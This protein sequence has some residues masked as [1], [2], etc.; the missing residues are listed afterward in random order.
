MAALRRLKGKQQA[1]PSGILKS[2][3]EGG[4]SYSLV[5]GGSEEKLLIH[6]LRG[7]RKRCIIIIESKR[8]E[9]KVMGLRTMIHVKRWEILGKNRYDGKG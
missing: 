4:V 8:N 5:S 9:S 2:N 1:Q 3:T 7:M 6:W